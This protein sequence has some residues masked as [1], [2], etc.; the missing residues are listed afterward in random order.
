V[1]PLVSVVIPTWNRLPLLREAVASVLAQTHGELELLIADDG[2][3]DGTDAWVSGLS[4]PRLRLLGGSPRRGPSAARNR[5]LAAARGELV[6]LLDSDDLWAPRK[7]ERQVA[8]LRATPGARWSGTSFDTIDQVG[9]SIAALHPPRSPRAGR[10]LY[11]GLLLDE[12]TISVAT[13]VAERSLAAEVGPFDEALTFRDDMEWVLRLAARSPV[14]FVDEPLLHVREHPGRGAHSDRDLLEPARRFFAA[15][16][17]HGTDPAAVRL[18][19]ARV[20]AWIAGHEAGRGRAPAALRAAARA[21]RLAPLDR[22]VLLGLG[23]AGARAVRGAVKGR[24]SPR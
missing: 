23:R 16:A 9:R 6:A 5:G 4:D 3:T 22:P 20:L 21:L 2:S 8:A 17:R 24:A 19:Q 7:L 11:R 12:A 13:V 18:A 15:A 14:A 1:A 10:P